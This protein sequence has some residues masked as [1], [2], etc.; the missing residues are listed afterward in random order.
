MFD[1]KVTPVR[2]AKTAAPIP[3]R[4]PALRDALIQASLDRQ[5]RSIGYVPSASVGAK[6]V[7]LDAIFLQRDDGPF[8][9]D[10]VPAR[11]IRTFEEQRL[12]QTAL[13]DLR[14]KPIV[15]TIDEI[16][17]EPRYAN[18]RLVW[19]HSAT[20]VAIGLRMCIL[21]TLLDE[22]AMPLG[23]LL[24]SIRSE[25]DPA[26]AVMALACANLVYLDLPT[27]EPH[28]CCGLLGPGGYPMNCAC[29]SATAIKTGVQQTVGLPA[30]ARLA[31][32]T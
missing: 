6:Q 21:L 26:P 29:L 19:S 2:P 3:A 18:A 4:H 11:R 25:V 30:G 31:W 8:V 17:Q 1:R 28:H 32:R 7:K 27:A 5:V 23:E 15:L 20:P 13:I 10:V 9:L 22:G 16:R 14:L 12:A 24:K